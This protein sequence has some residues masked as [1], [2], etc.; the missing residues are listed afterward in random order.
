MDDFSQYY[1]AAEPGRRERAYAWATAIGLQDVDGLKTSAYLT[2]TARENIEGRISADEA[3]RRIDDYYAVKGE[4]ETP[5][6]AKEADKVAARI[7][8]IIH[9]PAFRFS[10]E[11][12][13][14]L[15]GKIFEGVFEHAGTIRTVDLTKREWVLN[16]DTVRYEASFLIEKSLEYDFA[17]ET[18]FKYK[19]LSEDAFV[20]H[21]ASFISGI[22]QI[23]PFREGNTRTTALFAI[24]YLRSKGYDV[25]NDLFARKSFYFRNALV[26]ANYEN[27]TLNVEKTQ[28]PLEEFF[29][30]LIYG[31]NIELHNRFLKIGQEYGSPAGEAVKGLHRS[32]DVVNRRNVGINVGIN[33]TQS[34]EAAI[35]AILRNSR[36]TATQ[37]GEI[38]G[39][40]SRQAERIIAS[41]KKKAG[42]RRRGARKNGEWHFE[43]EARS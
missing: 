33:F 23:H 16:G 6:D 32:D 9:S 2:E 41:L 35:K 13:L 39:I 34:E 19:G 8:Q 40:T 10:P 3:R 31:D 37:L 43:S 12:L 20:A 26:R 36:L 42:L 28:L 18:K 21:F 17:Q 29:K 5:E 27:Q 22:W 7:N 14:G 25:T 30:V 4:H 24:K 1:E 11:F 38:L 15:H